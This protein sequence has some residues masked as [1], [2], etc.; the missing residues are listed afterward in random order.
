MPI[1]PE[2]WRSHGVHSLAKILIKSALSSQSPTRSGSNSS[3]HSSEY[4]LMFLAPERGQK[5]ISQAETIVLVMYF[6]QV[7]SKRRRQ[8]AEGQ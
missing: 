1:G 3:V 8:Q 6:D 2:H 4:K 7:G 5:A